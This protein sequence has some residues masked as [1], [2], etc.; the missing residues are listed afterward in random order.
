[1]IKKAIFGRQ[2]GWVVKKGSFGGI[3]GPEIPW[4]FNLLFFKD[5]WGMYAL[6]LFGYNTSFDISLI[7]FAFFFVL[8][9]RK[10]FNSNFKIF[11]LL[12]LL[13]NIF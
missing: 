2:P 6:Y 13:F 5:N 10:I 9:N 11:K 4:K 12:L 1:L 7:Y 8:N 3:N